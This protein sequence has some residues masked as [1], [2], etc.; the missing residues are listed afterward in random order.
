MSTLVLILVIAALVVFFIAI[1]P[2]PAR[3]NLIA[4]G[5]FLALLA[6]TLHFILPGMNLR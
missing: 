6:F 3:I 1:F 4:L 2:V 5:L